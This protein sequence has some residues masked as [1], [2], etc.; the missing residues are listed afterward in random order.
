MIEMLLP[1]PI[2]RFLEAMAAGLNGPD[3]EGR[4]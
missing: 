1:D 3:A 2:E 4:T